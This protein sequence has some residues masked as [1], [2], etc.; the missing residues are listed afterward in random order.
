V[1]ALVL[2]VALADSEAHAQKPSDDPVPSCLDQSIRDEL[3]AQIRPRGVQ[4]RPFLKKGQFSLTAHGGLLAADQMS[5]NYL[6]GG[7]LAFYFTE[8]LALEA[9]FDVTEVVL[10]LDKPVAE[11]FGDDRF[12]GGRAYLALANLVWN[13]IHAKLKVGDSIVPADLSVVAGGGRLFHDSV[14]GVTFDAGVLIDFYLSQWVTFRVDIRD[15]IAIQEAVAE[16][17]L[18]NNIAIIGGVSLWLPTW[19]GH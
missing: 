9:R 19:H 14:Q 7:A 16:T 1:L 13:P 12:E 17:R 15:V 18:T 3:G 10:D 8:D 11:F 4:K 5:S 6:Y 2:L